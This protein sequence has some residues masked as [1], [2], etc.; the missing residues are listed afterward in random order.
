MQSLTATRVKPLLEVAFGRSHE[1][2]ARNVQRDLHARRAA[3]WLGFPRFLMPHKL[4][5]IQ[6]LIG[7]ILHHL[8]ILLP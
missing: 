1:D 8:R 4:W 5:G 6:L 7:L 2:Q 3:G